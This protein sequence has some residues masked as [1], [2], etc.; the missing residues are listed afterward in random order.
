MRR[1][2]SR[3]VPLAFALALNT[4]SF[5][6]GDIQP[7][8]WELSVEIN[9][10]GETGFKMQQPIR[11]CLSLADAKD[12]SR[13]LNGAANPSAGNCSFPDK[14]ESSGHMDFSVSCQGPL[15]ITGRGS[16]DYT[17]TTLQGSLTLEFNASALG[18][19]LPSGIDNRIS[20]HRVGDC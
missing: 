4:N 20:G 18:V 17:P 12:P 7:G 14:R 1:F 6:Q 10:P 16:I 8:M 9:A 19:Q 15:A 11:Q 13:I 3:L 2:I 5:A